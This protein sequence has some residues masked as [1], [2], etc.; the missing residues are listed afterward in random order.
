MK[1]LRLEQSFS[2]HQRIMIAVFLIIFAVKSFRIFS[3]YGWQTAS[4]VVATPFVGLTLLLIGVFFMQNGFSALNDHKVARSWFLYGIPVFSKKIDAGLFPVIAVLRMGKTQKLAWTV[5]ANPD[6]SVNYSSFDITSL[7]EK[8]TKKS[9]LVILKKESS[10]KK[11]M[12][13]ILANSNLR[14]E[15]YSPDFS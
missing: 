3:D 13:F 6:L 12:E 14:E 4:I 11:A 10:A 8:H 1:N 15:I 2:G 7:N 9:R 5:A